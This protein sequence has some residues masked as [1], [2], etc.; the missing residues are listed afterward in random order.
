MTTIDIIGNNMWAM[1][2]DGCTK[3]EWLNAFYKTIDVIFREVEKK[4]RVR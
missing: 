3:E 2:V 1:M 4:Q